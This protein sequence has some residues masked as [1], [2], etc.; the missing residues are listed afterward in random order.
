[1]TWP[2]DAYVGQK[3]VCVKDDPP[4]NPWHRQF[5]VV[6]GQVYTIHSIE[7]MRMFPYVCFRIDSS[8]RL[9]G[10]DNF[11]PVQSTETGMS[12]LRALLTPL[13]IKEKA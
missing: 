4:P 13:K 8:R 9:W 3:V 5:P 11:R 2:Q 1:M 7:V 10:H 12:V 6:K